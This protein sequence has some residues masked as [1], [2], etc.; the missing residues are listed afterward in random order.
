MPGV[1]QAEMQNSMYTTAGPKGLLLQ[2]AREKDEETQRKG[3]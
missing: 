2:E 3:R 1:E